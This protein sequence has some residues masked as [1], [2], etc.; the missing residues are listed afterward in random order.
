MGYRDDPTPGLAFR[1]FASEY[2][3]EVGETLLFR[4]VSPARL[5]EAATEAAWA[6]EEVRPSSTGAYYMAAL[7]RE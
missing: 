1:A 2:G 3:G 4:L 6:A 7:E 5:R